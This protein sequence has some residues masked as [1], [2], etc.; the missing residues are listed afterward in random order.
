MITKEQL[1]ST[2][3]SFREGCLSLW[4][5]WSSEILW[6]RFL[7]GKD[8]ESVWKPEIYQGEFSR[9][10]THLPTPH[11]LSPNKE[12]TLSVAQWVWMA[13]LNTFWVAASTISLVGKSLEHI[14]GRMEY[15][16]TMKLQIWAR[17]IFDYSPVSY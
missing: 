13:P 6:L 16:Q 8:M 4:I 17:N 7:T 2:H 9:W 11:P 12:L 1:A 5:G 14:F 10:S 3:K 15:P